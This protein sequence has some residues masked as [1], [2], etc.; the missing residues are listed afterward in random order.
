LFKK[1]QAS[2]ILVRFN[3]FHIAHSTGRSFQW[4]RATCHLQPP[5]IKVI[6]AAFLLENETPSNI[7]QKPEFSSLKCS[8]FISFIMW[9]AAKDTEWNS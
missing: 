1:L 7:I 4:Y 3:S 2:Q 6:Q 8:L 9:N 5:A